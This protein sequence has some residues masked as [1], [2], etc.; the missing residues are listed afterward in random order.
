M[1]ILPA[2]CW[3]LHYS[4]PSRMTT[5]CCDIAQTIQA[6]PELAA[7]IDTSRDTP[8]FGATICLESFVAQI[9]G[10]SIPQTSVRFVLGDAMKFWQP[11]WP[12][13]PD[14]VSWPP[15]ESIDEPVLQMLERAFNPPESKN[16]AS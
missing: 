5:Y 10:F 4:G 13:S 9:A 1:Q 2:E 8:P 7:R 16:A 12:P 11:I 14:S 6:D 3:D 15:Q